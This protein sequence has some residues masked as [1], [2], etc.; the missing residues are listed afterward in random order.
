M[1]T[2]RYLA[3][4]TAALTLSSCFNKKDENYD[5][6]DGGNNQ[7]DTSNP[8]G[9][10]GDNSAESAPYQPVNPPADANPTYGQAAYEDHGSTTPAPSA[11]TQYTTPAAPSGAG[12]SHVVV[13]GDTLGAIARNY[14]TSSAAIKQAN[15]MTSDTVVLGKKLII[16]GSSGPV[17]AAPAPS[18]S[19]GGSGK[20]HV[21]VKGDSLS[22]I[23]AKHGTTS[24]AIKKA[25]GMK[26]DTVVLGS[27][28]RIP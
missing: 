14:G 22:K 21:V 28:L 15:G 12:T 23:A 3:L 7:Y 19:A 8:Y 25:N 13:K 10:P 11:P 17:K 1:S 18:G 26:S 20:V 5:T 9:V 6:V 16:P 4:A 2:V 27:K 24:D